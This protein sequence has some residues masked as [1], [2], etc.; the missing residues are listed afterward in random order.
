MPNFMVMKA[1]IIPILSL[2]SLSAIAQNGQRFIVNFDYNKYNLTND[3]KKKL[4]S[5]VHSA[6]ISNI[7]KINL[8]GHCDSIGSFEYNDRL[9]QNRVKTVQNYLAAKGINKNIFK[10]ET[11]F[12]K[13]DPLTDNISEEGRSLNRRV[14]ITIR[15]AGDTSSDADYPSGKKVNSTYNNPTNK[16]NS[17]EKNNHQNNKNVQDNQNNP[18]SNPSDK[19]LAG[20]IKDTSTKVGSTIILKNL[21]FVGGKHILL[22]ESVPIVLELLDVLKKNPSLEIEIQGHVCCAF[23][24]E[25][26]LDLETN[27]YDLSVNRAKAVYQY[28]IDNGIDKNRLSFQGFAHRFPLVYP[29]DTEEKKTLNRRVEIKILKK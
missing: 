2:I 10:K 28:L 17:L 26:G 6:P 29:E 20:K 15:R 5:F 13:R 8:F 12:G 19:S 9:S 3:A 11:G 22:H 23:G 24:S 14:E 27:T 18:N 7:N 1:L 4:D 21:N 25:D 16:D